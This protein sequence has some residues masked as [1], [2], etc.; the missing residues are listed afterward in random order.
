M[1]TVVTMMRIG[2]YVL[3]FY[4]IVDILAA[5]GQAVLAKAVDTRTRRLVV[6][7]QLSATPRDKHYKEERERFIRAGRLRINHPTIVDPIDFGQEGKNWY[8]VFP[9]IEGVQLQVYLARNGGK[10]P[11]GERLRVIRHIAEGLAAMHKRH[12]VHR[13]VKPQNIL[14]SAD[15]SVHIVDLGICRCM[16]EQTITSGDA[17]LCTILWASPE[18]L[19]APHTVDHRTDLYSLGLVAY[20]ILTGQSPVTGSTHEAIA[21]SILVCPPPPLRQH[22]PSIPSHVDKAVMI[23]LAKD[24]TQRF[25]SVEEF[26]D[27]LNGTRLSATPSRFCSSCGTARGDN[28]SFCSCCGAGLAV[29]AA[30]ATRCLACGSPV[31]GHSAC[32]GCNRSFGT[33][34]RRLV[35]FAGPMT[36]RT[37]LFPIGEYDVGRVVLEPRD[38]MI[39]SRHFHVNCTDAAV[40]MRDL[41]STNGTSVAGQLIDH[42]VRLQHGQEVAFALNRATYHSD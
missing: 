16:D 26:L 14:V 1:A 12:V 34:R 21:R 39:S 35:V 17:F 2:Q 22:D 27:A 3:T 8:T 4:K 29:D 15:E 20:V 30:T 13:D 10:L 23:L 19:G 28:V 25:Q 38:V 42:E 41:G 6:I 37:L 31:D 33:I 11:V 36:G 40:L 7:K 18:Q 32:P 24:R 9:F 5:G